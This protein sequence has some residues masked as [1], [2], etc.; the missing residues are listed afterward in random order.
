MFEKHYVLYY[1]IFTT[2][3][4]DAFQMSL[5][6]Q[7]TSV[8]WTSLKYLVFGMEMV[9]VR[10]QNKGKQPENRQYLSISWKKLNCTLQKSKHHSN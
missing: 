6:T 7:T 10:E 3:G 4:K 2:P 8:F 5:P 9:Q 1:L